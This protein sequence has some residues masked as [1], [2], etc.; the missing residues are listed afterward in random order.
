MSGLTDFGFEWGP[1]EITRLA[2]IE[3]RGYLLEVRTKRQ[4]M[5]IY[6]SEKGRKIEAMPVRPV[7][8]RK[9]NG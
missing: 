9:E 8:E 2:H 6:V 5:Q 1:V 3:R 7:S 4:S